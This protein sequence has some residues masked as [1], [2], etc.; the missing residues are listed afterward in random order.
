MKIF[1]VFGT[2]PEAIKLAP[3]IYSL[4]GRFDVRIISTGQHL[5][6][7]HQVIDFFR[8]RPDYSFG[9]MTERP[10]L[11]KLHECI[12]KEMMIAIDNENP[13]LIIVQGDTL[14]T[15]A[16]AFVGFMLKKPVFHVE[17][18]LRSFDKYSPFPEEMLRALVSRLADFH[19]APTLKAYDN[20]LSEGIRKDRIMITGNTVVDAILLAQHL[21]NEDAILK[22]LS[23]YDPN[24]EKLLNTRRLA[25][26]TVHRRENI[27][28]PLR[29][30]CRAIRLL[31]ERYRDVLFLW[32]LH[33]N[34]EVRE[35]VLE[36]LMNRQENIVFTEALSY[37]TMIYLM[38]RSYVLMTDSGGIQEEAPAF[39]RPVMI[40]R[41]TTERPE[42]VDAG[43]GFIVGSDEARII[44]V[45][46]QFYEDENICRGISKMS[47]P[48]GDGKASERILRFL[49]LDNVRAFIK[50]YP[51]SYMEALDIPEDFSSGGAM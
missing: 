13:D 46:S 10:D 23:G 2:R 51:S 16:A 50:E 17:A 14:T 15:Y 25:L 38:E 27:G 45:F 34:P 35:I 28:K 6:M 3:V 29:D 33:K 24:I 32:P 20:L 26:I 5:D 44:G 37:Q 31:S 43:I 36:E 40:L 4:R 41:D 48:F 19:F 30:I 49:M 12:Q 39:G 1:I 7:T 22:E 21:I 42:V 11:E 8:L 18:G 9:C 47:N